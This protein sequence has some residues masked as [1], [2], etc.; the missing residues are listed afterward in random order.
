[1]LACFCADNL[2]GFSEDNLPG[3]PLTS[4]TAQSLLPWDPGSASPHQPSG[5]P[6][7][8]D[9]ER[10]SLPRRRGAT[11][12]PEPPERRRRPARLPS[13]DEEEEDEKLTS[14]A[15]FRRSIPDASALRGA[16]L[17]DPLA[18]RRPQPRG[19]AGASQRLSNAPGLQQGMGQG[20]VKRPASKVLQPTP[21]GTTSM[22]SQLK[23]QFCCCSACSALSLF[24]CTTGAYDCMYCYEVCH[25][26]ALRQCH[27][28]SA[29]CCA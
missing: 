5:Q 26:A 8:N 9:E 12:E 17:M 29:V 4:Q 15:Q 27:T 18:S 3:Q 1:M 10:F 14:E 11:F 16:N 23:V 20:P 2:A 22:A 28:L 6:P 7:S 19:A 21:G 13:P 24:A 25:D